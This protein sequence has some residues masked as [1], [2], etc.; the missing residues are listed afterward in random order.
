MLGETK[1]SSFSLVQF[2]Y[3]FF[4]M[5]RDVKTNK[6]QEWNWIMFSESLESIFQNFKITTDYKLCKL[7]YETNGLS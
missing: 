7:Q 5:K 6:M 1:P 4:P 2:T 3:F